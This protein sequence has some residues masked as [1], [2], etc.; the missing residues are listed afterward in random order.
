MTFVTTNHIAAL[1]P[2]L[3][4]PCR[5]DLVEVT[6]LEWEAFAAV[7]ASFFEGAVPALLR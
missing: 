3:V 7:F 6:A 4:R 5:I 1:D 2:A